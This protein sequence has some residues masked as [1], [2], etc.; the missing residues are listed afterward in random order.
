MIISPPLGVKYTGLLGPRP[1]ELPSCRRGV[2][3]GV[4]S[5]WPVQIT[6]N[7]KTSSLEA[8]VTLVVQASMTEFYNEGKKVSKV[9]IN[10]HSQKVDSFTV[11]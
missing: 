6:K 2:Q 8:V 3:R 10:V 5:L 9:G 4:V 1:R 7:Q 11:S